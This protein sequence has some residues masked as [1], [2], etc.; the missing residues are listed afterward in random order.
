MAGLLAAL[1]ACG[2]L[3]A[4]TPTPTGETRLHIYL[5]NYT[6]EVQQYAVHEGDRPSASGQVQPCS[7]RQVAVTVRPP[8]LVVVPPDGGIV[9]DHTVVG[10]DPEREATVEYISDGSTVTTEDGVEEWVRR[11]EPVPSCP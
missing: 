9:L 5:V 2:G 6:N 4:P 8:W 7:I 3:G 10:G 1:T 11:G